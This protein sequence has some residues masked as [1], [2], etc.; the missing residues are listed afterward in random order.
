M[1]DF[2]GDELSAA[3]LAMMDG[4]VE[5]ALQE[6]AVMDEAAATLGV[7]SLHD[8]QRDVIKAWRGG[9]DVLV[10]SGTGS[11]KSMC[12]MLPAVLAGRG[13]VA[14][15]ITPLI[16]LARDQVH[17]L[18]GR[19]VRA[20]LLGSGQPDASVERQAMS[21]SFR[22]VF[23]CPETVQRLLPQLS[24]LSL[25]VI[26]VDEA[27]CISAWGHD[28][29]PAFGQLAS[30]RAALPAAPLIA[31]TAT[32]TPAVRREVIEQLRMRNPL[33]CIESF[34]RANLAFSVHHSRTTRACWEADLGCLLLPAA[35]EASP[36]RHYF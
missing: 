18:V 35:A 3:D 9:R 28:F 11:G 29:R 15:V 27:H 17:R 1:S 24:Q 7:A 5:A 19:G 10:L 22:L 23:A 32:A 25:S 8:W 26:A 12:Y 14:L 13:T 2:F 4:A 34:F 21:G 16:S 6:R 31:L 30:V 33:L 20:C 36:L